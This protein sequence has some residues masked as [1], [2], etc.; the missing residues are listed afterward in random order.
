MLFEDESYTNTRMYFWALQS[1]RT[2]NDCIAS[3]ISAWNNYQWSSLTELFRRSEEQARSGT[4]SNQ[5]SEQGSTSVEA[6]L[7]QSVSAYLDQIDE[8]IEK[9]AELIKVNN[10]KQE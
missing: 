7:A 1:L 5:A 4:E 2:V 3:M 6:D 8:E 10:A 9:L